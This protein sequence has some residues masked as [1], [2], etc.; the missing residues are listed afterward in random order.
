MPRQYGLHAAGIVINN[1]PLNNVAPLL[2]YPADNKYIIQFEKEYIEQQNLLKIDI[3]SIANL[4]IV[5]NCLALVKQNKNID[6]TL[7]QIPYDDKNAINLIAKNKTMGLFQ[8]E[9]V[10]MRKTISLIKPTSF[11]DVATII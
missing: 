8:L 2:L 6:L 4:S 1:E 9:S 5:K 7:D 11:I 3:L 10:G